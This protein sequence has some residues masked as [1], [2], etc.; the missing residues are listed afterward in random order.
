MVEVG[1]VEGPPPG[2]APQGI[3]KEIAEE[4]ESEKAATWRHGDNSQLVASPIAMAAQN[5]LRLRGGFA[6]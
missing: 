4:G 5:T 3:V 6:G 1:A 2:P